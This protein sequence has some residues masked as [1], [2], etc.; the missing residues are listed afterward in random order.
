VIDDSQKVLV[1]SQGDYLSVKRNAS[2]FVAAKVKYFDCILSCHCDPACSQ[3]Y[4]LNS[5]TGYLPAL[6]NNSWRH[7]KPN[8]TFTGV[9]ET[10]R[11]HI[12]VLKRFVSGNDDFFRILKPKLSLDCGIFVAVE[13][14]D[15]MAVL[16]DEE[17][18]LTFEEVSGCCERPL[19]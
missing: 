18:A 9:D 2:Y 12:E 16:T 19:R 13:L 4:S 1:S 5:C 8:L 14:A 11:V 17:E 7:D 15:H 6:S 3:S 10:G